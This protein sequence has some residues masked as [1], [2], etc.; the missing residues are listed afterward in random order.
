MHRLMLKYASL[1]SPFAQEMINI[2]SLRFPIPLCKKNGNL[3]NTN[4]QYFVGGLVYYLTP[5]VI[6]AICFCLNNFLLSNFSNFLSGASLSDILIA[7]TENSE[8]TVEKI[9]LL[10]GNHPVHEIYFI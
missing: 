8:T 6:K 2:F 3:I 4:T 9:T 5:H 7:V 10:I 1:S